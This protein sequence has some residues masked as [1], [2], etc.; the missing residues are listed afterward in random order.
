MLFEKCLVC[1][2]RGFCG[3]MSEETV[4]CQKFYKHSPLH[5]QLMQFKEA[6][7]RIRFDRYSKR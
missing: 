3:S 6:S 4:V 5:V 2:L 7:M 1:I